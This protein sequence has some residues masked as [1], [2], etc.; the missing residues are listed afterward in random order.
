MTTVLYPDFPMS[1]S[2]CLLPPEEQERRRV[3]A[4]RLRERL[5]HMPWY[6]KCEETTGLEYWH[7]LYGSQV[8]S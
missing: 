2:Y 6:K 3:G 4:A 7:I 8:L 5:L 1:P